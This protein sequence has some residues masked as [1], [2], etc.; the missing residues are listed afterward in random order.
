M[1][2]DT[3]D[4]AYTTDA[5]DP[6]RLLFVTPRGYA[7]RHNQFYKRVYRPVVTTALPRRLHRLRWHDLRHTCAA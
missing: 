7:V 5:S 4:L 1:D 2:E 3:A 6:D